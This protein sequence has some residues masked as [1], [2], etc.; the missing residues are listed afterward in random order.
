MRDRLL[1]HPPI[2]NKER[3]ITFLRRHI[4]KEI[5]KTSIDNNVHE[6]ERGVQ[7]VRTHISEEQFTDFMYFLDIGRFL[8]LERDS[9]HIR[10]MRQTF[11][12]R[13]LFLEFGRR[14]HEKNVLNDEKDIFF[15]F[16][17]EVFD[18]LSSHIPQPEMLEI[19]QKIP[20]RMN[21]FAYTSGL[22]L[23]D[24]PGHEPSTVPLRDEEYY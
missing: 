12:I 9:H 21:A 18:L 2:D 11:P 17:H 8:Q 15:L 14:L 19:A 5:K 4:P 20:Q 22:T 3:M 6:F 7:L 16:I 23:H 13:A 10:H 24:H 1:Y